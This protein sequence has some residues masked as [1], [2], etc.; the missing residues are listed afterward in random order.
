MKINKNIAISESG[1]LFNPLTGEF[2]TLNPS[3]VEIFEML[4]EEHTFEHIMQTI[5]SKYEIDGTTFERDY[6]EFAGLLKQFN[7]VEQEN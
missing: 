2:F 7:L 1:F 4:R 3:G 5:L 6:F